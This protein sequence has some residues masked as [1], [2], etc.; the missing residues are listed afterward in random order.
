MYT[1]S[2][3]GVQQGRAIIRGLLAYLLVDTAL[4]KVHNI[5]E[6]RLSIRRT[7]ETTYV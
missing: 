1:Q 2:E 6:A 4:R 3:L 5:F 7:R